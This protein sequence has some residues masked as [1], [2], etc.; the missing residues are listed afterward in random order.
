MQSLSFIVAGLRVINKSSFLFRSRRNL[1]T[2]IKKEIHRIKKELETEAKAHYK[3]AE[4]AV[5]D[6][7]FHSPPGLPEGYTSNFTITLDLNPIHTA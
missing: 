7:N 6:F 1:G 4:A 3:K 2:T 5:K